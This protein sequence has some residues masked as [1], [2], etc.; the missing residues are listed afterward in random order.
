MAHLSAESYYELTFSLMQYHKYSLTELENMIPYE[1]DI[2]VNL[3]RNY[4]ESEKMK[5][6]QEQG[7]G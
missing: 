3:L 2:Y 4:L 6:Q 1:R 7:I 5:R